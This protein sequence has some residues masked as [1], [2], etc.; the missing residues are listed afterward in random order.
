MTGNEASTETQR[1]A[2]LE[3]IHKHVDPSQ[4]L[5]SNTNLPIGRTQSV[6][7]ASSS[8][9]HDCHLTHDHE[10]LT[11]V[12]PGYAIWKT[13]CCWHRSKRKR[14]QGEPFIFTKERLLI[15]Y[16]R[17]ACA[18]I[19][20][21]SKFE[22]H[23]LAA[24]INRFLPREIRDMIYLLC[25]EEKLEQFDHHNNK[26]AWRAHDISD[27]PHPKQ[28]SA[29][30]FGPCPKYHFV[31]PAYV[32]REAALEAAESFYRI[33]PAYIETL[34][35]DLLGQY[36]GVDTFGMGLVPRDYITSIT[37]CLQSCMTESR[38]LSPTP[39]PQAMV[40][41][42]TKEGLNA[43]ICPSRKK[44]PSITFLITSGRSDKVVEILGWAR[45]LYDQLKRIGCNIV[46]VYQYTSVSGKDLGP[47]ELDKIMD[48]LRSEWKDQFKKEVAKQVSL[49][50]SGIY[51]VAYLFFDG[52][53]IR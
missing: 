38:A 24:T 3:C 28:S 33:S 8:M 9:Y 18:A 4:K 31:N 20:D 15:W 52:H 51:M 47:F 42:L 41:S 12:S 23:L 2:L 14:P 10:V 19:R 11:K 16:N 44:L 48:L 36:F 30:T 13:K 7:K 27:K 50:F 39:Y 34:D 25:W 32:G 35:T 21:C 26:R 40:R 5:S 22:S 46:I 6:T 37:F 53:G 43:M 49:K 29:Q 45:T 1:A 17:A